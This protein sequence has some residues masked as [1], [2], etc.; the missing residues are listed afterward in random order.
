MSIPCELCYD[1][2]I[3][4]YM[5]RMGTAEDDERYVCGACTDIIKEADPVWIDSSLGDE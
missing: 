2:V 1:N 5:V 3:Y 4:G